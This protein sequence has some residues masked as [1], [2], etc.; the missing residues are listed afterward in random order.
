[1]VLLLT[2]INDKKKSQKTRSGTILKKI[3]EVKRPGGFQDFLPAEYLAREKMI[4]EID[5][6]FRLFGFDPIETPM[7]EFIETLSSEE[8]E[9]GKNIFRVENALSKGDG[10]SLALRFDQTVPFARLLAAN[11]YNPKERKGIKLPWRRMAFGPVFRGERQQS[12]RYRQ[13]YQ[14]DA[15]IAGSDS[16]MA[17]AEIINMMYR[18]LSALKVGP[19]V[20]KINNRKILNGLAELVDITDRAKVKAEDITK[21][22]MRILDKIDKI[23]IDKVLLELQRK[24][25]YD[26]DTSPNLSSDSAEK[27]KTFLNINGNNKEKLEKC[28]EVFAGISVAIEGVQEL[29]QILNY[30]DAMNIPEEFLEINF[31]IARGLDYYTGPVMET[32]LVKAPQFGSLCSGGRY[33]GLVARFT[34]E[35]I[36]AVGT[37]IGVDRLFAALVYLKSVDLSKTT[38]TNTMILRLMPDCNEEYMQIA[39]ELRDA[40]VKTEICLLNDTTFKTQFNFAISRGVDFVVIYGEE[41]KEKGVIQVKNLKTREQTEMSREELANFIKK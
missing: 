22:M 17:D 37:S 27:I 1:M 2:L 6:I 40:G 25:E 30:L 5:R 4:K 28:E 26:G 35:T 10:E 11:P 7:V 9:T 38:V 31:S 36:P 20:I 16:M 23:G 14:F 29:K 41:E 32:L 21:E 3:K 12:G 13:F 33:N 19:F 39:N 24:P 18:T 34:G 15:D 8:S